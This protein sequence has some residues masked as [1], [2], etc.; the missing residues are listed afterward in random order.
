MEEQKTI[1]QKLKELH[2]KIEFFQNKEAKI[3]E[4]KK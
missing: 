1:E 2:E 4:E 3:T